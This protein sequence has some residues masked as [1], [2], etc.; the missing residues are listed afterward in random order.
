LRFTGSRNYFFDFSGYLG[1]HV[2]PVTDL[3]CN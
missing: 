3:I 1:H 2:T